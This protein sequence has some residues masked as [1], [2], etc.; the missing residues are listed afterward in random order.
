MELTRIRPKGPRFPRVWVDRGASG[1]FR[2]TRQELYLRRKLL[3]A[4]QAD[5][6]KRRR[7]GV[8]P[9]S[10]PC[11][12]ERVRAFKEDGQVQPE[13]RPEGRSAARRPSHGRWRAGTAGLSASQGRAE[14]GRQRPRVGGFC[15][16]SLGRLRPHGKHSSRSPTGLPS[17]FLG[18]GRGG[19]EGHHQHL[20]PSCEVRPWRGLCN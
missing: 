7:R 12:G 3:V 13:R 4:F 9:K 19:H 6:P 10:L 18:P 1:G 2:P 20:T 15:L 16:D 11:A 17:V 5:V 8:G 14:A